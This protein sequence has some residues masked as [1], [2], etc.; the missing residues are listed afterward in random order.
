MEGPTDNPLLDVRSAPRF[1]LIE[2]SH[3]EPAL[4]LLL[5]R[6]AAQLDAL[7]ASAT[8]SWKGLMAPAYRLMQ[9]IDFAWGIVSHYLAVLNSDEW[10]AAHA[11]LQPRI[12]ALSLRLGQSEPL[13]KAMT[14]LRDSEAW[15]ELSGPQKR[16]LESS[17]RGA[18]L[19]GV[20]LEGKAKERFSEVKTQLAAL[21]TR[22]NNTI[23]DARKAF[24]IL[25]KTQ[26]DVLGLPDTLRSTMSEAARAMGHDTASP[27]SGPWK[28]SLD[29]TVMV[30]F[31]K[32]SE[33]RD[34][35]EQL[36]RAYISLA[37]GGEHDNTPTILE[38]LKLRA[39]MA[40]LLGYATYADVS[41]ESKMAP[42][43][44]AVD[45]LLEE[46]LAAAHPRA[47]TELNALR[48]FARAAGC[49]EDLQLWDLAY[50]SEKQR[51]SLFD[52]ND[53]TLRPYFQFPRVLEGLFDKT[54]KLF[55]VTIKAAD[56]EVPVWHPDVRYF[57][58]FDDDGTALASFYLDPYSRPETKRAGAW[59]DPVQP[60]D[61]T[62]TV[63]RRPLAYLVCNQSK[64]TADRPSLMTFSEVRTLFH[65]F[66]HGLQHMLT[67]VGEPEASGLHNIEWDAVELASQFMENWCYDQ[68][69]L[70]GLGRHIDSGDSIPDELL[71]KIRNSRTFQAG[72]ATL[73]QL[74][75]GMLDMDLHA[76]F[77]PDGGQTVEDIVARN[78]QRTRVLPPLPEDHTLCSF[79]HIFAGGYASGYYSY[80]WSEVLSADTFEAF[81]AAGTED[82]EAMRDIGRR[83]RDTILALGGGTDP[84]VVFRMFM[85]RDPDPKAL[86]RQ[87]G[88]I[89]A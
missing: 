45:A 74:S 39:E 38:I 43:V 3:A 5:A 29:I 63:R 44:G 42:N 73:R 23:L 40:T 25:L 88:L 10:R 64:P 21:A 49:D 22:F 12:V 75:L 57:N 84:A 54:H 70:R 20:G 7:E 89:S 66:G 9:P 86:L 82:E 72:G 80:K 65:E 16:I 14:V 41:L 50:W 58:V 60:L 11:A 24:Y 77:S 62:G 27:Q 51:E 36:Y 69:T 26:E 35:R 83:F 19:S 53:E 31:L 81:C 48:E 18:K 6:A 13:F 61:T 87:E 47:R 32:Y 56:G 67:I 68:A 17:I 15:N 34:L 37:S 79:S 76:R 85:G 55:G 33:R 52:F 71:Q 2:A 1:D 30:P 78:N 59:M 8:P 4:D 46:L 28:L